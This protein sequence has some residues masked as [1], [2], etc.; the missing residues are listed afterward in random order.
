MSGF[1]YIRG[2]KEI[3]TRPERKDKRLYIN[4]FEGGDIDEGQDDANIS[5]NSDTD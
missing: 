1:D 3:K 2:M 4:K 5:S